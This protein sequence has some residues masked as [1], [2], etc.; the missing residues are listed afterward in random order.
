MTSKKLRA[1]FRLSQ[2][3][4]LELTSV[5]EVLQKEETIRESVFEIQV[6]EDLNNKIGEEKR[7][8]T[9]ADETFFLR[10]ELHIRLSAF[11]SYSFLNPY[12]QVILRLIIL[13]VSA[14]LLTEIFKEFIVIVN[15]VAVDQRINFKTDI[16]I[17][18]F[19]LR[20]LLTSIKYERRLMI[21]FLM[22]VV[23]LYLICY[24]YLV[25]LLGSLYG[26]INRDGFEEIENEFHED[27]KYL[28]PGKV[29]QKNFWIK[30]LESCSLRLDSVLGYASTIPLFN[31]LILFNFKI[32]PIIPL[33]YGLILIFLLFIDEISM[34]K[35]KFEVDSVF[36]LVQM[37]LV[38][39]G[40]GIS[41]IFFIR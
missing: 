40:I 32:I 17:L 35:R 26:A 14:A 30:K 15:V 36:N 38:I 39:F 21:I 13:L 1:S 31:F 3:D 27:L 22:S 34:K 6:P 29:L 20:F 4:V 7:K 24:G 2:G 28:Q 10:Q 23:P 37:D 5:Q 12:I 19:C 16:S 11:Q 8:K 33:H 18:K 9:E 41:W 25:A